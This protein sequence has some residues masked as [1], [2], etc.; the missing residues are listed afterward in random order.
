MKRI[1]LLEP[2]ISSLN[3]GDYIIVDSIKKE[4]SDLLNNAYI[5]EQPTQTP[6]IHFYQKNDARI[7]LASEADYRFVCGSNLFWQNMFSLTPQWNCNIFN[8]KTIKNSI[9]VGVG[10]GSEK[11]RLGLYT[12]SL[13]KKILNN[14]YIHSVRDEIT[15]KHVESIGLRAINTGCATMWSLTESHCKKIPSK[16]KDN[17]VFTL[18]DYLKDPIRDKIMID[19]LLKNYKEVYYWPQG[20]SDYSYFQKLEIQENIKILQP[21]LQSMKD[22]LNTNEVDYVGTRLHGGIFAMQHFTRSIIIIIDNR[23]RDMKQNYNLSA[24]ERNDINDLETLINSKWN[25][26]L[27]INEEKIQTW[28]AQFK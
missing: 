3:I 11:K 7:K 20:Y 12:T 10:S 17:V 6:L 19:I 22:I 26:E 5:V 1:V 27:N 14:N 2:S 18:T 8:Y 9:L 24:I 16:K 28:K 15:K 23:A 4:L 13:Y 21:N 25:T